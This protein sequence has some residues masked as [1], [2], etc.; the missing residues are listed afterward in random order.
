MWCWRHFEHKPHLR[1]LEIWTAIIGK[2]DLNSWSEQRQETWHSNAGKPRNKWHIESVCDML[3]RKRF[4][5]TKLVPSLPFHL[6]I[7]KERHHQHFSENFAS[8]CRRHHAQEAPVSWEEGCH[9][10]WPA[11]W[12]AQDSGGCQDGGWH[13]HWQE[14]CQE[15]KEPPH[16]SIPKKG[17]RGPGCWLRGRWQT[18]LWTRQFSIFLYWTRLSCPSQDFWALTPNMFG[19]VLAHTIHHWMKKTVICHL[20]RLSRS[21][22][23]PKPFLWL[24]SW[25]KQKNICKIHSFWAAGKLLR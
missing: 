1:K 11:G 2:D 17:P 18:Q 12:D 3:A 6:C 5:K 9:L 23:G 24:P 19:H 15:G 16:L 14:V 10:D 22:F 21:L 8:F 13:V 4:P 7:S 25:F 20:A